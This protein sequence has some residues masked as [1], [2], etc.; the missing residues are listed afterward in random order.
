MTVTLPADE[1]A[2]R[3]DCT[4]TV[5]AGAGLTARLRILISGMALAE[6]TQRRFRML[7]PLTSH[8]SAPFEALLPM[9][10]MWRPSTSRR[11]PS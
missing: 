10:G 2:A 6:M 8:C 9:P 4:L 3:G 5:G 1:P 7:G 11:P